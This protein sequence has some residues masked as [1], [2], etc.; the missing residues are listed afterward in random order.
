MTNKIT[1]GFAT[2]LGTIGALAGVIAPFI[3]QL[4]DA[5]EPLGVPPQVWL[6][7]GAV[8]AVAVILGRMGQ[9]MMALRAG[10][11]AIDD[12]DPDSLIDEDPVEPTDV[13]GL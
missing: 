13:Q 4:A 9:A 12:S 11:P 3:G 8:C 10:I 2:I 1:V 5:S 6:I 7:M